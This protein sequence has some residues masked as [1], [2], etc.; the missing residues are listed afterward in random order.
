MEIN[1]GTKIQ[2]KIEIA[3]VSG[4]N[5]FLVKSSAPKKTTINV[6]TG[7]ITETLGRILVLNA[8]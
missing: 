4:R 6:H 3:N 5:L 2:N 7:M 1:R 8:F